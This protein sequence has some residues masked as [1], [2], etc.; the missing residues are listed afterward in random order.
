MDSS[1]SSRSIRSSSESLLEESDPI[2]FTLPSELEMFIL[3]PFAIADHNDAE[4]PLPS[5]PPAKCNPLFLFGMFIALPV[6][7]GD[8]SGEDCSARVE[9]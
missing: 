4:W 9:W 8:A 1:I 7:V 6:M 5:R 2:M 3:S